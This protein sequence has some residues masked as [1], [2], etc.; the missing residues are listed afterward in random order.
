LEGS[1]L[2]QRLLLPESIIKALEAG[3]PCEH[4]RE[5]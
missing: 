5:P 2:A 1:P 4:S 3:W